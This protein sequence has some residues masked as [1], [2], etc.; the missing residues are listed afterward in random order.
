MNSSTINIGNVVAG[1]TAM[2]SPLTTKYVY[3]RWVGYLIPTYTGQYTIGVNASDGA[4]LLLAGTPLLM[5]LSGSDSAHSTLAYTRSTT[6]SLTA[7][8]Y[9]PITLEW[10]HGPGTNYQIQLLWTAPSGPQNGPP[11]P[12]ALIPS[13]NLSSLNNSNNGVL[14]GAGWQGTV[15]MWYPTGQGQVPYGFSGAWSS[16]VGYGVGDEVT[17]TGSYWK[18][19]AVN[20]NSAPT[21]SNAN[22][23]NVGS[24]VVG[25]AAYSGTTAYY[26]NNQVTYSGNVYTAIAATT[27]NLPTNATYWLLIGP[28]NL[29]AVPDGATYKRVVATA[30]TNNKV[31]PSL[32]GVLAKGSMPPT[33]NSGFT[34]T[35]TA[36]TITWS[37]PANTA[38]YRADGSV[39]II[40]AG[41]QTITGLTSTF[42]YQFYP[43]WNE[44]SSSL[45]FL[46]NANVTFPSIVGVT[47]GTLG[48][49]TG[50]TAVSQ[51]G[52]FSAEIWINGSF[53]GTQP[54][55]DLSAPDVIGTAGNKSFFMF[56]QPTVIIAQALLG[57]SVI[58]EIAG[59][60]IAGVNLNDGNTHHIVLTWNNSTHACAVYIDGV[61]QTNEVSPAAALTALATMYWHI[62]GANG[63]TG[64]AVTT[65]TYATGI[66]LS[67]AAIYSSVLTLAQVQTHYQ[68]AVNISV[69]NYNTAITA[70]APLNWWK[71]NEV[72]GTPAYDSGS[73]GDTGT[74][75][76]A[77]TLN[78]SVPSN[79]AVGSPAIA[80]NNK[81]YLLAQAASQ[82]GNVPLSIGAL[83][84][85]SAAGGSGG[86]GGAPG[87]GAGGCFSP[88]TKVKTQRGCVPF[89][90]LTLE[91][92]VL[93]AKGTW[94]PI[95]KIYVH[96]W[97]FPMLNMGDDELVTYRHPF[98]GDMNW[99]PAVVL[100]G[101]SQPYNGTVWNLGIES[102]E[103]EGLSLSLCTERSYT[104]GNGHIVH[105]GVE[106]K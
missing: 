84:A 98:L 102:D 61:L 51:P 65:D 29:D 31:D 74:Y 27:G 91:D 37:W 45:E 28:A 50:D 17:Y 95:E 83:S 6:I 1:S 22:W 26:I 71:L 66:T 63:K 18:S 9:Y 77:V 97:D 56:C 14:A 13:A 16:T 25:I 99:N 43:V 86:G 78:V 52:S 72:T 90:E 40:G 24:T 36:T 100:F 12:I 32:S 94:R 42:A 62:G 87:G 19:L 23:Q 20:L 53:S 58:T 68:S 33:L 5:N 54:L 64:W 46:G 4:N 67:N 35:S 7:G 44:A 106:N 48:Y 73:A 104:L 47:L 30:L 38:V 79:A 88:N 39:T 21:L 10:Q 55:F 60:N 85:T 69:A 82:Q 15:V 75:R 41:T 81:T 59:V 8:V 34:Y 89:A 3:L 11:A 70:D 80:Y 57:S 2:P 96:E 103:P 93:T 92:K 101:H 76:G 105:N 49:V